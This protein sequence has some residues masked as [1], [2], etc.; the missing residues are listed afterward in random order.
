MW[1]KRCRI[2]AWLYIWV[3]AARVLFMLAVA[4]DPELAGAAKASCAIHCGL[5][6]VPIAAEPI[7]PARPHSTTVSMTMER[8][9]QQGL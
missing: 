5:A 2:E 6:G 7:Q 9:D 1:G 8:P 4:I 3:F